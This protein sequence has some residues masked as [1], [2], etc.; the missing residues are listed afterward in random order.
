MLV[1]LLYANNRIDGVSF[2]KLLVKLLV[3]AQV[4]LLVKAQVKLRENTKKNAR[5]KTPHFKL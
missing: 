3:E 4:K 2:G 1:K 5:K